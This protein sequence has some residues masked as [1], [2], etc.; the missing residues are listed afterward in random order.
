M[1]NQTFGEYCVATDLADREFPEDSYLFGSSDTWENFEYESLFGPAEDVAVNGVGGQ[2]AGAG[3]T[4]GGWTFITTPEDISWS[5]NAEV[6][7]IKIFGTNQVPVTVGSKGMREL[8]LNNAMVEGFTRGVQVEDKVTAL[9]ALMNF[10]LVS[11]SN[12]GYVN[13]PVYRVTANDKV[14]GSGQGGVDGGYFV[15]KDIKVKETIRDFSGLATRAFVDV[16]LTQVPPYQ[17]NNGIDQ[18]NKSVTGSKSILTTTNENSAKLTAAQVAAK[19][20]ATATAAANQGVTAATR[21]PAA[22]PA[23]KTPAVVARPTA[24]PAAPP[25]PPLRDVPL[26]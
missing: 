15:I 11:G 5:Q 25:P 2:T 24:R 4:S 12:G 16:S 18:A 20:A 21:Q 26:F 9:E 10:S 19:S 22:K 6:T 23:A 1:A 14:Y 3:P 13:V 7:P 17:V 8:S